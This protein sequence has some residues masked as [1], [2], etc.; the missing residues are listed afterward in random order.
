MS[1]CILLI[2]TCLL[3]CRLQALVAKCTV[4]CF[5]AL[6]KCDG[7]INLLLYTQLSGS[8]LAHDTFDRPSPALSDFNLRTLS[9]RV[10]LHFPVATHDL[11]NVGNCTAPV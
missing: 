3:P 10:I 4:A 7:C 5:Q 8:V 11:S 2:I 6:D 1:Q 9:Q